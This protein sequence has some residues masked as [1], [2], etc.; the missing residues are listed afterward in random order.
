MR[1]RTQLI[2]LGS[3]LC[4]I[5]VCVLITRCKSDQG[6]SEPD[7]NATVQETEY[8]PPTEQNVDDV[9]ATYNALITSYNE[10][11]LSYNKSVDEISMINNALISITEIAQEAIT[12]GAIPYDPNVKVD[13]EQAI[14]AASSALI[15]VPEKLAIKDLLVIPENASAEELS[16]LRLVATLGIN[17]LAGAAL[18]KPLDAPDYEAMTVALE[19]ALKAFELSV[20]VQKQITAPDDEFVLKRL[21]KI[22][23]V[24]SMA[25]VTAENDPNGLL[26]TEG[27]YIGCIYFSDSNVDKTQLALKPD[28]YDVIT[29]GTVG[30]GAIEIYATLEAAEDRNN[31]LSQYDGSSLNPGSHVVLGT[32]VIRTSSKLTVEQQETLTNQIISVLIE[33]LQ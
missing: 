22:D 13:L 31:Y 26:G 29:M 5:L 3:L 20:L 25:A 16:D 4:L 9:V 14:Q 27:G 28:E 30:G 8:F 18:P 33:V 12:S 23:T 7:L 19:D 1:K 2:L 17:E 10:S 24:L 11:A 15:P 6:Q 21:Q 32:M